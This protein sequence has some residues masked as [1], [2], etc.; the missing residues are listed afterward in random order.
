MITAPRVAAGLGYRRNFEVVCNICLPP[1]W[2]M[3]VNIWAIEPSGVSSMRILLILCL[4]IPLSACKLIPE[5]DMPEQLEGKVKTFE[6]VVRWG[7]LEKIYFFRKVD[8]ENPPD[9][10]A[11]LDNIR[12]TGY[13]VSVPLSKV[14][15]TR[16]AQ[17]V[18]ID[19]V[20][21]DRQVVRQIVDHQV[22]MTDDEGLTWYRENPV[23]RF[24]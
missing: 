11:G 2:V 18:V 9:V 22:W 12:V 16:W 10:Q 15:E 3:R 19:Y 8:P 14:D 4:F 24:R 6:D 13:E 17:S 23:P 7:A 21:T 5:R 1:L 20:W